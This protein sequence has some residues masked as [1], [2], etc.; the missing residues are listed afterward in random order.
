[1]STFKELTSSE[2]ISFPMMLSL[3]V[4]Y[5]ENKSSSQLHSEVKS[6][7]AQLLSHI[8]LFTTLW[9]IA[10]QTPLSMV[11]PRQEY[12]S[13]LPCPPPGDLSNPGIEPVSPTSPA[14]A[15]RFFTIEPPGKPLVGTLAVSHSRP[16]L[17]PILT[18][19]PDSFQSP[20]CRPRSSSFIQSPSL[21]VCVI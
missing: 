1:M 12:W 13:G 5:Q 7:R 21:T 3:S 4:T 17:A 2:S 8:Q 10:H 16:V 18:C 20:K 11:P 6:M 15:G 9:T 19:H 14:S